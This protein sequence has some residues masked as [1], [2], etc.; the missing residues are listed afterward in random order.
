M[1]ARLL[2]DRANFELIGRHAHQVHCVSS[3]ADLIRFYRGL[4][5]RKSGAYADHY[6][7]TWSELERVRRELLGS[8]QSKSGRGHASAR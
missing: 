5:E 2:P 6:E 1:K 7:E 4:M 3:L 8:E